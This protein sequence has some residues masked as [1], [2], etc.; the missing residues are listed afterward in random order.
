MV[1]ISVHI[2]DKISQ[3]RR[4]TQLTL[5]IKYYKFIDGPDQVQK[6]LRRTCLHIDYE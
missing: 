3:I 1:L 6:V 2:Q 4:V 5:H